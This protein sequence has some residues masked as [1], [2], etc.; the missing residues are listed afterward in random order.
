MS[1]AE[2][3]IRPSSPSPRSAYRRLTIGTQ[4]RDRVEERHRLAAVGQRFRDAEVAAIYLVNGTFCGD[5][6]FGLAA[7]LDRRAAWLARRIRRTTNY[8]IDATFGDA[9]NFTPGYARQLECGLADADGRGPR[10][11]RLFWS[12]EN[13]HLARATGALLVLDELARHSWRADERIAF[14]TQSHGGNVLALATRLLA[15]PEW[16]E[17]FFA[18][19]EVFAHSDDARAAH[20]LWHRVRRRLERGDWSFSPE[21]LDIVTLGSPIIYPFAADGCGQLLHLVN[22]RPRPELP[23]TRTSLPQSLDDFGSGADGDYIHQIGITGSNFAP[24]LLLW[25]QF[26]AN[27]R[28]R[29]LF[30]ADHAWRDYLARLRAGQRVRDVGTTL[31]IDYGE[32]A[33]HWLHHLNG[34]GVYTHRQ[35]LVPQL[36]V[37]AGA[38]YDARP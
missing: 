24:S 16:R 31:L 17:K 14:F 5:D 20:P 29:D 9:G 28:L 26:R 6:P 38:L 10:A 8:W 3:D 25:R 12:G 21:Q 27:L 34:H 35:W 36:E 19:A 11:R 15:E 2:P 23:E 37:I 32:A 1:L 13:H 30:G 4:P 7:Q 33:R 18:A 22:H